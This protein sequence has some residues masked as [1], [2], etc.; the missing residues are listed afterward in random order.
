MALSLS[1]LSNIVSPSSKYDTHIMTNTPVCA[2]GSRRIIWAN[3]GV[4][5]SSTTLLYA[6]EFFAAR[7]NFA[8]AGGFSTAFE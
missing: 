1:G 6:F 8:E 5:G 3:E 4:G 2:N 7:R